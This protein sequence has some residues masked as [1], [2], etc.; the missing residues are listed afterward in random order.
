MFGASF[1]LR[2]AQACVVLVF[3]VLLFHDTSCNVRSI[4]ADDMQDTTCWR[5]DEFV[6]FAGKGCLYS[7]IIISEGEL[8]YS[9]LK[10]REYPDSLVVRY[11]DNSVIKTTSIGKGLAR[12]AVDV[13]IPREL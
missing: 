2:A 9:V 6:C 5:V 3:L 7:P 11:L 12:C 1:L 8:Q 4:W 13:G 10:Q